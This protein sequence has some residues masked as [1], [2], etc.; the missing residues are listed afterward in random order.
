MPAV[1]DMDGIVEVGGLYRKEGPCGGFG[2]GYPDEVHI[3][4]MGKIN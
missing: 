3:T 1:H 4:S 2:R